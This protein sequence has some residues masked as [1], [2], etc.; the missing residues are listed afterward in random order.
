MS[1]NEFNPDL[2]NELIDSDTYQD[3]EEIYE[4]N[5]NNHSST[6]TQSVSEYASPENV[7]KKLGDL[8][9]TG[10]EILKSIQY[11]IGSDPENP[12][13]IAGAASLINSVKDTLKEFSKIHLMKV[14]FE[15][16]KELERLK[17]ENKKKILNHKNSL[18]AKSESPSEN[19]LPFQ[20]EQ[21]IEILNN[22]KLLNS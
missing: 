12:E 7:Y 6:E 22:K 2:L 19:L 20:Q 1:S 8:V 15:Q 18:E 4:Q 10:N 13:T 11:I 17:L 16:Q 3:A 14:K 21:I 5:I 9:E